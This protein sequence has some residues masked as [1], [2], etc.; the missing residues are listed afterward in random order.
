MIKTIYV[1]GGCFWGVEHF[2][3]LALKNIK[4]TV[5]Y[6]NSIIK[7]P[8]YKNVCDGITD[9]VEAV[10]IEFDSDEYNL[11]IILD[12]LFLIIDPT[13]VNK[14]GNDIGRQY[15]TGIYSN[16]ESDLD[17]AKF[18]INN[19]EHNYAKPICVEVEYVKNFY[20]AEEY[21]QKYLQKNPNGYCHIDMSLIKKIKGKY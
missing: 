19:I 2:Y 17:I 12:I 20:E 9:A 11:N 18:Y 14:Q 7:N 6:L 3:R 13:S 1:A 10:K 21:H 15:R 4:T 8:N 5:G 16:D